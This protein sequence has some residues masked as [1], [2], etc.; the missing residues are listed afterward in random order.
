MKIS[1]FIIFSLCDQWWMIAWLILPNVTSVT[2]IIFSELSNQ[3]NY[4]YHLVPYEFND[5][6]KLI[7]LDF[8]QGS[9]QKLGML[10]CLCRLYKLGRRDYLLPHSQH[11]LQQ[12]GS[13]QLRENQNTLLRKFEIKLAQR[14]GGLWTLFGLRY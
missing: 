5:I 6:S 8:V 12:L 1:F 13:L 4:N 2:K 7:T 10:T 11:V 9:K 14:I 3:D